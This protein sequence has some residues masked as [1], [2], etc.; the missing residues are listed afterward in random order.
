[1]IPAQRYRP[2]IFWAA[3]LLVCVA[4]GRLYVAG[5]RWDEPNH[6]LDELLAGTAHKPFV[7]R[8]LMPALVTLTSAALGVDPRLAASVWIVAALLGAVVALRWLCAAFWPLGLAHDLAALA[9]PLAVPLLS[10]SFRHI[11][12]LPALFLFTL[13][14]AALAHRRWWAFLIIY[15]VGCINK[16]T[17]LFLSLVFALWYA[18]RVEPGLF[19]RLLL[20][21]AGIY[22]LIRLP[23]LWAFRDNPGGTLTLYLGLHLRIYQQVLALAL[24][25]ALAFVLVTLA[26]AHGWREKPRGL[27]RAAV[28]LLAVL[29]P[30]FFLFGFPFE[31]RVF[32]EVFAPIYLLC[33]PLARRPPLPSAPLA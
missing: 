8:V 4:V 17:T 6:S 19:W 7:S 28:G 18:R 30:L 13:G 1:M 15:A 32:Y 33:L 21:Q 29:I 14:L 24:V 23:L 5:I 27:R 25:H 26:C 11:Y 10:L 16:E 20:M 9:M 3:A 31:V 2:L 22:L 12:D